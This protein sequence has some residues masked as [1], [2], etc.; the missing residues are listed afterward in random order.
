M[1]HDLLASSSVSN[2]E[3]RSYGILIQIGER[4]TKYMDWA[5]LE[6]LM[7]FS[8]TSSPSNLQESKNFCSKLGSEVSPDVT[9]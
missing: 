1:K 5:K 6:N 4:R 3:N 8:S 7:A 9:E 2:Y